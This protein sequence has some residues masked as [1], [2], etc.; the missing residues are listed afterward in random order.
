M[1]LD[2]ATGA[3]VAKIDASTSTTTAP[4]PNETNSSIASNAIDTS[5]DPQNEVTG[6]KLL[7]I[8]AGLCLCTFL[9][10]LV[11]KAW[12]SF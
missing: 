4:P 9:I 11:R 6:A 12:R 5:I 2:S 10:G 1:A 7:L 8:H 3:G